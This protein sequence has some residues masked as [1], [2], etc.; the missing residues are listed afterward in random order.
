MVISGDAESIVEFANNA[1]GYIIK[2]M[3]PKPMVKYVDIN[4]YP[5]AERI[6]A[7]K[8]LNISYVILADKP[9]GAL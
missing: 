3:E 4:Y 2:N 7:E 9:D 5:T 8:G 1:N 6:A